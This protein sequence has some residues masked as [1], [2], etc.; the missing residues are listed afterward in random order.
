[1][2]PSVYN[3]SSDTVLD[4]DRIL[5]AL[6]LSS[7]DIKCS[8]FAVERYAVDLDLYIL[9]SIL[10]LEI[11]SDVCLNCKYCELLADLY[12]AGNFVEIGRASC[13]ERVSSP[14]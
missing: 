10:A 4:P 14:V 13:R 11:S 6:F 7:C 5:V 3:C 12:I 2:A 1:M 9:L 8:I